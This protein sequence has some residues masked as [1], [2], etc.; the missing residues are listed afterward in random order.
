MQGMAGF[1]AYTASASMF[2]VHKFMNLN[3]AENTY[4]IQ[5]VGMAAASF[6]VADADVEAV[7]KS[8]NEIF[9]V[10]CAPPT[11]VIPGQGKQLQSICIDEETCPLAK[12]AM[13]GKYDNGMDGGHGG[14]EECSTSM[15]PHPTGNG[16]IPTMTSGPMPTGTGEPT[17]VP[18]A[19]AAVSGLSLG[20]LFAGV[21]AFAL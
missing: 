9:N 4:F 11:E 12:D 10:R 13:C 19:G 5:Q 1:D 3:L 2:E 16:T 17:T 8:L 14:D 6:G 20:A 7:G 18:T 15:M 21:A